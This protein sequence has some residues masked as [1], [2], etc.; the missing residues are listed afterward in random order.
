MILYLCRFTGFFL[1]FY[2]CTLLCLV[3]AGEE[4]LRFPKKKI[5]LWVTMTALLLAALFPLALSAGNWGENS[6][7]IANLYM[8]AAMVLYVAVYF[9]FFRETLPKKL[10][11]IFLVIFYAVSQSVRS[12]GFSHAFYGPLEFF[13]QC[14]CAE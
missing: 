10:L 12:G 1:Q 3:P 8:L 13:R 9:W 11:I 5:I 14:I 7:A 4:S 2:P 6:Y